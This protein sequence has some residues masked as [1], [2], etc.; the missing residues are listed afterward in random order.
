MQA[1]RPFGQQA[2][3]A[4]RRAPVHAAHGAVAAHVLAAGLLLHHGAVLES[5][6]QAPVRP[7]PADKGVDL[8]TAARGRQGG[9]E[10][11]GKRGLRGAAQGGGSGGRGW[12]AK[13]R[14]HAAMQRLPARPSAGRGTHVACLKF[15][16]MCRAAPNWQRWL[17]QQRGARGRSRAGRRARGGQLHGLSPPP[18]AAPASC[19]NHASAPRPALQRTSRAR[20]LR[21][22]GSPAG[23]AGAGAHTAGAARRP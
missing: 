18:A 6:P 11:R 8:L 21:W 23:A 1:A 7:P 22:A 12:C 10:A 15:C 16:S 19:R 2:S 4:A 14:V 20:R 5:L 3:A 13:R 17:L 9:E